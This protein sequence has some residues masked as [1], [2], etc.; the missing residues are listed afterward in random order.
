MHEIPLEPTPAIST[1]VTDD[2]AQTEVVRTRSV[3]TGYIAKVESRSR[4]FDLRH[5]TMTIEQLVNA[6]A[7]V[8]EPKTI[9]EWLKMPNEAFAGFK[10][11]KVIER[12]EADR[13]WQ[14]I[15]EMRFGAF[16]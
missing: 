13:I 10:P 7:E 9:G 1:T 15:Y 6:L 16:L 4:P 11:L 5:V 2:G 12:G 14:M 8:V 3:V